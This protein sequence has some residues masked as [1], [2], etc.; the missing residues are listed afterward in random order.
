MKNNTVS[1]SNGMRFIGD[2]SWGVK[3]GPCPKNKITKKK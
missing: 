2:G 1:N 3:E